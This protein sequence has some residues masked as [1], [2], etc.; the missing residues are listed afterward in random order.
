MKQVFNNL[1][2]E[3]KTNDKLLISVVDANSFTKII[4]AKSGADLIKAHG[5]VE[6]FFESIFKKGHQKILVKKYSKNGTGVQPKENLQFD[7]SEKPTENTQSVAIEN[8]PI[9]AVPMNTNNIG[10]N[11]TIG[12]G[13]A[14]LLNYGIKANES[15]VL[16]VKNEFLEKENISLK[17]QVDDLKEERLKSKYD[18]ETK[19]NNA[20][21]LMGMAET[22][23][24][25]L[26]N[27]LG[28]GVPATSLNAPAQEA[29]YLSDIKKNMIA[30]VENE[31]TQDVHIQFLFNVI[32]KVN[33]DPSFYENVMNLL[34]PTSVE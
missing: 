12:L 22:F 4:P 2:Q 9:Q 34:N 26:M 13:F 8:K 21:M 6:N 3:L 15:D 10:M 33:T 29:R 19:S 1:I 28:K 11:G 17:S 30:F 23:A 7:F 27:V 24:P 14:E 18:T 16:R 25:L 20:T 32:E 31:T 5:S